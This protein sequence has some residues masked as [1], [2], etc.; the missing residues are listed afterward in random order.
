MLQ[1]LKIFL[2]IITLRIINKIDREMEKRSTSSPDM[3]KMNVYTNKN[4]I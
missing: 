3:W 4:I 1:W 2:F